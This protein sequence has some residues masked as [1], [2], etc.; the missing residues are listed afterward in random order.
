MYEHFISSDV[1]PFLKEQERTIIMN[2]LKRLMCMFEAWFIHNENN[3]RDVCSEPAYA[4]IFIFKNYTLRTPC[5][6]NW[7]GFLMTKM[8]Y[9]E[10][11]T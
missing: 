4:P 5:V 8:P 11:E 6:G 2:Q 1:Y 10:R 9:W 3:I 7:P